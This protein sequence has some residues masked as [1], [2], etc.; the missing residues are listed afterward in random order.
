MNEKEATQVEQTPDNASSEFKDS[1][2]QDETTSKDA[3]IAQTKEAKNEALQSD[4]SANLPNQEA[5]KENT[6]NSESQVNEQPKADTTSDS[7]V[8]NT[9]QQDPT[10]TVPSP[11]TSEDNRPSTELKNSETTAS[12]TTLNEQPTESTSNQTETTKAPTNTT[13]AN[14]QA[15]AQLKDIKGTTQLRAVSASQPTAVAAGGTNVNDKVT[16]SDMGISESYIE[17]NNSGSF[18]LKSRFTVDGTVKEGDYFT[19]KMPNTVNTYG[20]TRH[21]PDFTEALKNSNGDVIALGE[22]DVASHTLTYKFTSAVNNLQNVTGSFNLT[23]FM[24]RQVAKES[25]TYPLDYEIAGEKF[26][27]QIKV[28]Y[29]QYYRVGDSNLKSMITMEDSKTGEYEQYIYVN[30]LKRDAYGTVVRVQGFQNDPATSNGQVNP[31]TT[32]IKILKVSDGQTLNSSFGVDD[33]QYEDVTDKFKTVY[34]DGENLADIFLGDLNGARYIIKVTSKEVSGSSEDLKL[35]S[36]MY[37]K[38]TYGQYDRLTWDN[39]IVKSSSGG[40]ADGNEASYQLGDKVWNDVNK[41]GIQD[42]GETGIA[43]VKVTLKDLDG[44]ILDTTYT[45]TNGKYIFDNLKNGN[46]QV[47]FETPEGYAASPSNQGNDALDSDG[48]TNAQAVISDG[49]NL[50]VDQGFYQTET[51]THNVG[52]K[53]WE[54]L[55]KDGIQDQNEPGI[56][57]VKVTLKDADG[58]VVDTRTTDDKGNY[59]FEKVKEGEYTIEFETPEGYTPTQTGQGRVSTDSNGTSSLILVEGNDDL[60]IDSGFYKEPVTHKVGDKVWDDLN[61][62]GIQDDNE[63]GISNV[64]VTLKDADGNVVDTRT[65]DAN[66]NYLFENVKEGDY[67]IEFETPEGYTP[68]VTGQ[69]TADNDSNGTS[70]KVTVKDGDDLTIDSGFTQV[71]PEPPTHNVGDKVWDDLNKDG[72]QDDNEPGISNVKVTLKDADGNVVDTRTT[73]ANGNYLFENVKEGDYTIEFETPEGYTPTVTGQ[74][75]ADNDSNG[76]ST[77]VT[78]KD[79]DDLTIDSGFTQVTPEPPTHNVGDKVWDDLNKDGIQDDNEPGISN[80]KV[81]LKDADGNVVDTRTTD[82]NGNYLF[83]NVKEGDYTIE[84]ETPEGYTPTV[85]GQGTSDNDSNGT[86]TK[87]TVKDGDDLTIDSGFTQVTPEPPTEPENPSPEQPSEPGQPENPSPEQPSEPGQPENPSPEQPSEPGQP[88]NPSPEQPSEPGQPKN[89]SPEQPNNPSVPGVQ[90][91][92]K[93]SLTPVTQPVHSNGNKAKPSQQQKAL[94]ETG[95]TESHQGTLFGGILA[96]LG[97]LLFARKKRHDKKQ[98]H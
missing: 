29:G 17:P 65:T 6:T 88:E 86:S 48:P 43:D 55:N 24:D 36:S 31:D 38:N 62:D 41:N 26:D 28:H 32:Q 91:P 95:E 14:K 13:V 63:P 93:P 57:N 23:Q 8:S 97:A 9:P 92:E 7:Q 35:R 69:G 40:T 33:S 81:T 1:A 64:K 15:P 83:E 94:P 34:R 78:V 71:T 73:D 4:S 11:E 25:D 77:K 42:Q 53:V 58:N 79:G 90:N 12:Q 10:S 30:P 89:P 70:T 20:D 19:V 21:S 82:A 2:A 80:V 18:Y 37:T 50:T 74:G 51:P 46:Y 96:A 5:E 59:L 49:N 22:Y 61:K 66:G 27:T 75:T 60:T 3:D 44:N 67:T 98:S 56:A 16:A 39:D 45:N 47:D 84:F 76:T 72:I 54:D 52:D 68:T 87:V 85:T